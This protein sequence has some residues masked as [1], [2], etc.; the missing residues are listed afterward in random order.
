[1]ELMVLK[2]QPGVIVIFNNER[3]KIKSPL[4]LEKVLVESLDTGEAI[5]VS[6]SDLEPDISQD[7]STNGQSHDV[8]AN[9]EF[10]DQE[11]KEAKKREKA[12]QP[13]FSVVCPR[14]E[15]ERIGT[16]LGISGRHVYTLIRR[17]QASDGQFTSLLPCKRNGGAGK[18]RIIA[19]P[20]YL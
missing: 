16:K 2:I 12:T 7:K 17:Y 8:K 15:A 5:S 20:K 1:M 14:H 4:S 3:Y 18:S 9:I 19:V 10:T 6:L 11:W 13:Y